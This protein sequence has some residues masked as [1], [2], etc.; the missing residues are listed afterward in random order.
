MIIGVPFFDSIDHHSNPLQTE[1]A[2][3]TIPVIGVILLLV[4]TFSFEELPIFIDFLIHPDLK[5]ASLKNNIRVGREWTILGLIVI[6]VVISWRCLGRHPG[7]PYM[8]L[9]CL[10]SG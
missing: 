2:I 5:R 10:A 4:L 9:Q 6:T 3:A 7:N 8:D 1:R